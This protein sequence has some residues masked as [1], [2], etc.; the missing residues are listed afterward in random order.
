MPSKWGDPVFFESGGREVRCS[1]PDRP[2]FP[3]AGLLKRDVVGYY[4]AVAE[5]VL[6]Q[7]RDRPTTLERWPTGV[8]PDVRM[9]TRDGRK[10]EAFYQKRVPQGAP[11]YVETCR[12]AFPSGRTADEVCPTEPAVIVWLAT[13]GTITLHPWPV[14]R[15]EPETPD[16]LRLDFDPQ[17]GTDFH[18]AVVAAQAAREL[19]AEWG[20]TAFP[21]TSGGRGV[22]VYVRIQ[23]RWTF[24]DMRH[25]A[26][27]IGRE[28]E[29]RSPGRI[30]TNWWKEERGETVFVDY[31]QNARDRTIAAAWSVRARPIAPVST[32]VTWAEL[33]EV[34]P[35]DFTVRTVPG[36]LVESGDP[37]RGIDDEA[38]D[39]TPALELFERDKADHG[40]GDLPYPP[41]YPKMPGEPKRVQPSREKRR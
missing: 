9:A 28:L 35:R 3:E 7:I 27:A 11:P 33:P 17:P 2:Y 15:D 38:F 16:E 22:H 6:R 30:T 24:T 25:A 4:A 34:D 8:L 39:L 32:P 31:N 40:L 41:E 5:A 14:R 1:N 12:I 18:D 29:R 36:R 20:W 10:G 23:R 19:M 37:W 13:L 21:K 26:I